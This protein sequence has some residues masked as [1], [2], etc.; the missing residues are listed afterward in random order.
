MALS[1]ANLFVSYTNFLFNTT[2]P[3]LN[4]TVATLKTASS[5][6]LLPERN[7]IY[8]AVNSFHPCLK[9]YTSET[10]DTSLAFLKIKCQRSIESNGLFS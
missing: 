6:L 5:L 2:T 1:Y 8:A 10:S 9:Y 4:S 3:G 7:S